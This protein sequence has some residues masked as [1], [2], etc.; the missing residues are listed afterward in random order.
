[1]NRSRMAPQFVSETDEELLLDNPEVD[2]VD[3]RYD[4]L[5]PPNQNFERNVYRGFS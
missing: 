5:H 3:N 4:R 1:M 2:E